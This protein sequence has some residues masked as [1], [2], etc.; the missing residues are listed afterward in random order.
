MACSDTYNAKREGMG[1]SWQMLME[2]LQGGQGRR[3]WSSRS[4]LARMN[5]RRVLMRSSLKTKIK[6]GKPKEKKLKQKPKTNHKC[7][8]WHCCCTHCL[9]CT[10]Y[11]FLSAVEKLKAHGRVREFYFLKRCN[12]AV[13]FDKKHGIK[14]HIYNYLVARTYSCISNCACLK[15][16]LLMYIKKRHLHLNRNLQSCQCMESV[17]SSILFLFSKYFKVFINRY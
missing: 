8:T 10:K 1:P 16:D 14:I 12:L 15:S 3:N 6:N 4:S 7:H 2:K 13:K 5:L 9:L 11:R 17:A